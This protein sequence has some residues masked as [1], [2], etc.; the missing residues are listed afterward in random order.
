[1]FVMH[2]GFLIELWRPSFSMMSKLFDMKYCLE[3]SDE[4]KRHAV[5]EVLVRSY[6]ADHSGNEGEPKNTR[7]FRRYRDFLKLYEDLCKKYPAVENL[8]FPPKKASNLEEKVLIKRKEQL[9]VFLQVGFTNWSICF[10]DFQKIDGK[11]F[12]LNFLNDYW[13]LR[14]DL[15]LV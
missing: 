4:G 14:N 3:I 5:Y 13:D 9:G 1:M 11:N 15:W 10:R 12:E 2:S 8:K 7:I 6:F